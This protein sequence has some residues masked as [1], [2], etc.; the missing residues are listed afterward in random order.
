MNIEKTV[1][2]EIRKWISFDCSLFVRKDLIKLEYYNISF[3]SYNVKK[4]LLLD[5]II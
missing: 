2:R 3:G 1:R 5:Y 4:N